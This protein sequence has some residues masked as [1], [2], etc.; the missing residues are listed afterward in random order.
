MKNNKKNWKSQIFFW[1]QDKNPAKLATTK[2]RL[3][4]VFAC[5]GG[6]PKE[7]WFIPQFDRQ[8][9]SA[10]TTNCLDIIGDCYIILEEKVIMKEV[11]YVGKQSGNSEVLN[12]C[13]PQLINYQ[14]K[15]NSWSDAGP[16]AVSVN[17][18]AG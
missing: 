6:N 11:S 14:G 18:W 13:L 1:W 3:L 16:K 10:K 4:W 5:R 9:A 2:R 17:K 12:T 7:I 8:E 15:V